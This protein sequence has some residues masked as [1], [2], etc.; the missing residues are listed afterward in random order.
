[1]K[2]ETGGTS[3]RFPHSLQVSLSIGDVRGATKINKVQIDNKHHLVVKISSITISTPN[4]K[5]AVP[6]DLTVTNPYIQGNNITGVDPIINKFIGLYEA[7]EYNQIINFKL[8]TLT[9]EHVEPIKWRVIWE[10][11]FLRSHIDESKWNYVSSG[12]G[13]GNEELQ[14]YTDQNQ[15]VRIENN[16]LI[17]EA[18]KKNYYS[19]P[20][21]AAKLTTKGKASWRYGRFSIRAKLPEGKG[22]WPAFWMMPDDMERYSGWPACGEIDIMEMV[23]HEADT[24]HGTLHYGVPHTYKGESYKLPSN[25][26][27][28]DEF[29]EFT[30]DWEPGEFRWYVDG[31]LYAKQNEWFSNH[32]GN[33]QSFLFPAPFDRNFYLQ[34]NIAVGGKWPGYPD[35]TTLFPQ[36]MY[37]EYIKV[38]I[39]D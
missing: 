24:V 17:I 16:I 33:E 10:D 19:H 4:F 20:Y 22:I 27:F 37:V 14:Y 13:F 38:F 34:L 12:G 28:S 5:E 8:I 26:R 31:I 35:E 23:G 25:Q 11:L 6:T 1:M 3:D 32:V 15:N 9:G 18:Q 30:L 2:K 36:R 39:K 29:H 21:T 7:N